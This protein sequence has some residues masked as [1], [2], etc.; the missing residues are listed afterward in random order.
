M[1]QPVVLRAAKR[2]TVPWKNGGGATREL[3]VYPK[4]GDAFEWRMSIAEVAAPGPFSCFDGIDRTS[5]VLDGELDLEIPDK[6]VRLA[7]GQM[8]A[9]AGEDPVVG[10]PRG[11][12]VAAV[13][14][15]ARRNLWSANVE[16]IYSRRAAPVVLSA[17]LTI[18]L[19]WHGAIARCGMRNFI[20]EPGDAIMAN[21]KAEPAIIASEKTIYGLCLWRHESTVRQL[22]S[23]LRLA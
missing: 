1:S 5:V 21:S 2:I 20:L 11:G 6:Q 7:G 10:I 13:N 19:F 12:M 8:I 23:D 17:D 9:F 3:A 16:A 4:A 18:F 22:S 15:M 14:V